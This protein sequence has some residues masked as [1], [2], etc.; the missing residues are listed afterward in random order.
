MELPPE[1]DCRLQHPESCP[2]EP[3]TP[4]SPFIS[5]YD[6]AEMVETLREEGDFLNWVFGE[7]Q[8]LLQPSGT[9]GDLAAALQLR[10]QQLQRSPEG[11][12][13]VDPLRCGLGG[14]LPPTN[15][16]VV[17]GSSAF[18]AAGP[19]NFRPAWWEGGGAPGALF[20]HNVGQMR[21]PVSWGKGSR[22]YP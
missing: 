9:L 15:A 22:I 6:D 2:E 16:V 12:A 21:W 8:R 20:P 17:S 5:G 18:K 19:R 10:W 7:L 11:F 3:A 13:A 4:A 14:G 1:P